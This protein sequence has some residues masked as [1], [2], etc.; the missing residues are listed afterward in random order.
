MSR[1]PSPD[2]MKESQPS[3]SDWQSLYDTAV[4]FRNLKCWEWTLDSNLFGVQNPANGEIGYCCITGYLGEHFALVVYLGTEGLGIYLKAQSGMGMENPLE[5]LANQKCLMASFEDRETLSKED[6]ALIKKLGLR[7]RGRNQWPQ[8]RSYQ[9]GYHPWY[10]TKDE[11]EYLTLAL[12]QAMEVSLRLKKDPDADLNPEDDKFQV[13]E[14]FIRKSGAKNVDE[15]KKSIEDL[16]ADQ[17][18]RGAV[19]LSSIHKAKGLESERVWILDFH[20][21]PNRYAKKDWQIHGEICCQYV[22]ITRSK[23][24]LSFVDSP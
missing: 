22:A 11:A 8:F 12:Q 17:N 21:L 7:F 6:R 4:E 24:F 1:K 10:L 5:M 14:K 2:F 19:V 13:I 15:L 3:T 20:L 23:R 16:F 18:K 9:P